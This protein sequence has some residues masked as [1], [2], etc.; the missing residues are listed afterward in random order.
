MNCCIS[1]FQLKVFSDRDHIVISYF[2]E[3]KD[4]VLIKSQEELGEAFKVCENLTFF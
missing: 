2:D 4:E 1:I 3:D